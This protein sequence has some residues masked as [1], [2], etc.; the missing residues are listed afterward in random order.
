MK[1]YKYRDFAIP[2]EADFG[3][4]E[5]GIHR[6]LI[7][8][9]RSTV[10]LPAEDIV[11][12]RAVRHQLEA[13]YGILGSERQFGHERTSTGRGSSR[14]SSRDDAHKRSLNGCRHSLRRVRSVLL[15]LFA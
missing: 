9:S 13:G 5:A 15:Q 3:R 7:W 10:W 6:H 14:S 4:L 11:L 8:C 2:H 12:I 1:I